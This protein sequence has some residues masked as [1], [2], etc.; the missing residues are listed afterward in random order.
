[1]IKKIAMFSLLSFVAHA[2]MTSFFNTTLENLQY[3]KT[4]SLYKQSNKISKSAIT[5]SQYA[6]FSA[7]ASYLI[8]KAKLLNN[9]FN[10][11][12]ISLRDTIDLFGKNNYKI[13]TLNLDKESKKSALNLKKEQLFIYLVNMITLYHRISEQ[14]LLHKNLYNE[15]K[16][17][18]KN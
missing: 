16:K 4:Y 17:I 1:M 9:S 7:D 11:T 13:I 12:D 8:T 3:D 10:T 6:N 2:D 5:Y 14:L 15:Q 18:N